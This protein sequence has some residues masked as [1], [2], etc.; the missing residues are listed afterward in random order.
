[1]GV[2]RN[3]F[4]QPAA[5]HLLL[6]S[7]ELANQNPARASLFLYGEGLVVPGQLIHTR[8]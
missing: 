8:I 3:R 2:M 5:S 4:D 7:G 1:M 6:P